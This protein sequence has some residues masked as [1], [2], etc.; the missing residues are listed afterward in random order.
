[1]S[2][3]TRLK[4]KE[5]EKIAEKSI[6]CVLIKSEDGLYIGYNFFVDEFNSPIQLTS[7]KDNVSLPCSRIIAL[8]IITPEIPRMLDSCIGCFAEIKLDLNEIVL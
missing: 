1:M 5:R 7:N 8:S 4:F 3:Y 6:L 2:Q